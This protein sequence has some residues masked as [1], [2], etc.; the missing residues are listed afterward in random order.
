ME[1]I[2]VTIWNE[3][4]HEKNNSRVRAIYPEGLHACIRDF[5]SV[6]EDMEITLAALD[7]PDQGLPDEVLDNTD[8]L[9][10]WG[11][12]AHQ[13]VCDKLAAKIRSRVYLG[14]MGFIALHSAHKSKPFRMI[15]G[16][17][18]NLQWGR[19]QKEIIW[20]LM[21][22]HPIAAG[23]PDH[24]AIESE[25]LYAEPFY[26]P[27][28]DALVFGA[29]FE[30]GFI[31]RSGACFIRGAGKVFYFQP[32]H[33]SCRSFYN[34]YVQRVIAN[35]VRWAKPN[36]FGMKIPDECPHILTPAT[37]DFAQE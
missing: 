4:R 10:W 13:E 25:E 37:A 6:N 27:Q 17:N 21:P 36:D 33:E 24:F 30:D 29:W 32:G 12:M 28:P 1:K 3:Y 11:H 9:I 23:I 18:G 14:K 16:T 34:P 5:L 15:V 35:A 20:N 8:V 7:D 31:F 26:I 19:N 2:R 22:S